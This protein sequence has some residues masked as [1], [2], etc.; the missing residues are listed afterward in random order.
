MN[1]VIDLSQKSGDCDYLVQTTSA[2]GRFLLADTSCLL[3]LHT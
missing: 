1:C 3:T 2:N